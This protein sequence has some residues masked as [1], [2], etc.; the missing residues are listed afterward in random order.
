MKKSMDKLI[1]KA[2]L[3][4][5]KANVNSSC[6]FLAHQPKMPEAAKKLRKF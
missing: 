2:A 5:T 3:V 4:V 6:V 1:A